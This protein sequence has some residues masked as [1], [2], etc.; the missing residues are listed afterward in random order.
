MESK[1]ALVLGQAGGRRVGSV[2]RAIREHLEQAF[3][4]LKWLLR[5]ILVSFMAQR[6]IRVGDGFVSI[7]A[8][9]QCHHFLLAL[10]TYARPSHTSLLNDSTPSLPSSNV[11]KRRE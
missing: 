10:Q 6:Q 9:S 5:S 11:S 8:R 2:E 4:H 7:S 3:S 1:P